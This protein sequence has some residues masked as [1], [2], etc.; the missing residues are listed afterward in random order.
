MV[1][2]YPLVGKQPAAGQANAESD[3]RLTA[4][5]SENTRGALP[6]AH[7]RPRRPGIFGVIEALKH[8]RKF[9]AGSKKFTS[10]PKGVVGVLS[11]LLPLGE[12]FVFVSVLVALEVQNQAM[13]S[14]AGQSSLP[15]REEKGG[16]S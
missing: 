14:R 7:P 4:D 12:T 10:V 16:R 3:Y 15:L 9:G 2:L 11:T 1:K 5:E 13:C 8:P 6:Y